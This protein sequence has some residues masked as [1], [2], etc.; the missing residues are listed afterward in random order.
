M[1]D[2]FVLQRGLDRGNCRSCRKAIVWA[3]TLSGKKAPFEEDPQGL[4]VIENGAARHVGPPPAQLELGGEPQPQRYTNH[5]ATCKDASSW[6][7]KK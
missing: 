4:Y 7:G 3:Y 1:S 6:R 5:F 2:G